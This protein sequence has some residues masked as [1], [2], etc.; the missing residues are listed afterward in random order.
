MWEDI[1]YHWGYSV[2]WEDIISTVGGYH[3]YRGGYLE[4]R[5]EYSVL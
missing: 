5:G 4:S 3:Q 2:P 1:E